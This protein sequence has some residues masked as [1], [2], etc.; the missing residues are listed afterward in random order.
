MHSS[1][2]RAL[3]VLWGVETTPVRGPKAR[4]SPEEVAASAVEL[5]DEIGLDAVSLAR[6]AARL[7]MTTTALYRYVDAKATLVELMVDAAIGDPPGIA[8]RDWRARARKWVR[9]LADRYAAHPWLTD[10]KATGMPRQPRPYAWIDALVSGIPPTSGVDA[11][12]L[13]LLLDSLIRSYATLERSVT[14]ADP[15]PWLAAAVA[16]RFPALAAAPQ[17]DVSDARAELDYAVDAVLRG[18]AS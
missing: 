7:G 8:G 6:V 13:A 17:Q 11:L 12:R 10:V 15:E 18:V 9:L 16:E 14:A 3:K 5:A 2:S 4:F 1:E